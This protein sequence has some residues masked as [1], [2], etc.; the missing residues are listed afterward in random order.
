[1]K[2]KYKLSLLMGAIVACTLALAS[3]LA[4]RQS[5]QISLDLS[6]RSEVSRFKVE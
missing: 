3:V 4:I 1:M 6:L 2:I 5:S